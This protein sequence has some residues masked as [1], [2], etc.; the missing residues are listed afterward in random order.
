MIN[1]DFQVLEDFRSDA[2]KPSEIRKLTFKQGIDSSVDGSSYIKQGLTEI[3]CLIKGPY[4]VS[5]FFH[6]DFFS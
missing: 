2:R 5:A 6:I 3:I 1:K 4:P